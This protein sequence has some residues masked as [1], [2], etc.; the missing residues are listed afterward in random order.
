MKIDKYQ[1]RG[2]S[3]IL[4]FVLPAFLFLILFF[5]IPVISGI[6]ISFH[7]SDKSTLDQFFSAPFAGWNNFRELFLSGGS[8]FDQLIDAFRNTVI[9]SICVS[10]GSIGLG[11]LGSIIVMQKF[12]GVSLVR[13]LLLFSWIVPSYVV[14]LL[15]GFM[16][17][18][19]EGIIN[20]LLFDY[21]H[22]DVLS[23]WFGAHWEYTS[24]GELIKPN[25]LTG[26]N[27]IWA[28]IVPTIW[29]FWPFCMMMFLAGLTAIP[30]EIYEAAEIDGATKHEQFFRITLP[31]LKPIFALI[32]LQSLVINVYSFNIVAMMFGN[33]SGFPGKHGDLLMTYIYRTTFQT[34]N[35]GLGA[36]LSTLFMTM[37]LV[38]VFFWYRLFWKDVHDN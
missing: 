26:P 19:E 18:Q 4:V 21:L 29:R 9:Y 7:V 33:G 24:I 22:W 6:V 3:L 34:W 8:T 5:L 25:W 20:T 36:A 27:T 23:G 32:V 2:R 1:L 12:K 31:I 14:G 37:M 30:K 10:V 15:W 38:T 35:L 13:L 17:Q 28:I 11:L 16:W